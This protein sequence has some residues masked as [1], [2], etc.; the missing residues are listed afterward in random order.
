MLKTKKYYAIRAKDKSW[1]DYG[2]RGL[3]DRELIL[4]FNREIKTKTPKKQENNLA[5]SV[6]KIGFGPK[7]PV[8]NSVENF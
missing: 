4:F 5:T 8:L 6:L 7:I 3:T 1:N 2:N